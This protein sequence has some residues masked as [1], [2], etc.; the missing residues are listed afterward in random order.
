MDYLQQIETLTLDEKI[1][2]LHDLL[3]N[4]RSK[5]QDELPLKP[6][7]IEKFWDHL[8]QVRQVKVQ[9]EGFKEAMTK[10]MLEDNDA[11]TKNDSATA[12]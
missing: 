11:E 9:F 4:I 12:I 8:R 5:H 6:Q 7:H 2:L 10:I 3:E 1:N